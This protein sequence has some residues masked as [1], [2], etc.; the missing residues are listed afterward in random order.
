MALI[1]CVDKRGGKFE[2]TSEGQIEEDVRFGMAES[3]T[4][5]YRF[6]STEAR[7]SYPASTFVVFFTIQRRLY[8]CIT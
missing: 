3:P 1:M 5:P 6:L 7:I 2:K 4:R 8:V